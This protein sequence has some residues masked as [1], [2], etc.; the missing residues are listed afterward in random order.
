MFALLRGYVLV[1][2]LLAPAQSF[3]VRRAA[4]VRMPGLVDSNSPAFW[5]DGKLHLYNSVA[6]PYLSRGPDQFRLSAPA[7]LSET[8]IGNRPWWIESVWQDSNGTVFAWYHHE[9]PGRCNGSAVT[10]PEIGALISRDGGQSFD[11]LGIILRAPEPINC[12]AENG[13]FGGGHGDFSVVPGRRGRFLYF[14]FGNYGGDESRQG[15]SMARMAISD[16][17]APVGAVWKYHEGQWR[18]PGLGGR[19]TPAFPAARGWEHPDADAFWG[20]SV[21]WNTEIESYVM[22]LNRSC[23]R[24]DWPQEGIYISFNLNVADPAGWSAPQK[25]KLRGADDWYPQVLGLGP[26]ETDSLAGARAR[27]YVR[28]LSLWEIEFRRQ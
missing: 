20:P 13:F 17:F 22:L 14:L 2:P 27:I 3:I 21:H 10:S 16:R 1:L 6:Q 5:R 11:D 19:V 7:M 25:L 9:W 24:P 18:E 15:V 4:P 26:G 28:G 12:S 23:C 8:N